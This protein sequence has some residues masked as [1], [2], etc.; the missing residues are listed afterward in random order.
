ML[1]MA[2]TTFYNMASV[3]HLEFKSFKFWS[4]DFFNCQFCPNIY[5]S[6]QTFIKNLIVL[7]YLYMA[8]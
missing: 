4:Q 6:V 3:R 7:F 1:V 8:G 2:K 5:S